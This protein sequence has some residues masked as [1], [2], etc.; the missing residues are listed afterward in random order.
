MKVVKQNQSILTQQSLFRKLEASS[1]DLYTDRTV[2]ISPKSLAE[3]RVTSQMAGPVI[4]AVVNEI[5]HSETGLVLFRRDDE[6]EVVEP[7]IPLT[8]DAIAEGQDTFMLE[9]LFND[10]VVIGVVLLRLGRFAV[11]L[12]EGGT[13]LSSK[14]EGRYVKNRHRAGGSSQ[15][16]FERSRERLIRELFDK[17]CLTARSI[18]G[19]V[20]QSPDLDYI[21][22]GGEK[23][24]L[25]QFIKRCEYLRNLQHKVLGRTLHVENPNQEALEGI[26]AEIYKSKVTSYVIQR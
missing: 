18:L 12:Y 14:T 23:H 9:D 2:Y 19:G 25:N 7:P 22:L 24:T 26:S 8:M 13:L 5:G 17:A 4:Q 6:V 11:G 3:N 16:R 15:R 1:N 20:S 21:L 10:P